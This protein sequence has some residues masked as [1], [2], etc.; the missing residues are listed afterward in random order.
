MHWWGIM[1]ATE[2]A[3]DW[4]AHWKHYDATQEFLQRQEGFDELDLPLEQPELCWKVIMT[5]LEQIPADPNDHLFQVL[6]AGMM[7]ALLTNHGH[8]FIDRAEEL[9]ERDPRFNLLLGGVWLTG[10]DAEI[11]ARVE[12]CRREVW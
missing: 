8:A 12:A 11:Q 6:A 9:A 1:N 10:M 3:A 4:I 5:V 2:I 7:E